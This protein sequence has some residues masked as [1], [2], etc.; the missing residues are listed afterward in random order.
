VVVVTD[1]DK[2]DKSSSNSVVGFPQSRTQ[3]KTSKD[4]VRELGISKLA[5]QLGYVQPNLKGHWCSRCKGIWYGYVGECECPQ[6]G[7]R[8]G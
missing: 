4:G 5:Q 2:K 6:C 3:T 8:N 1:Q 7:N